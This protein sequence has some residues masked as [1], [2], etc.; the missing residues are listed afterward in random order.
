MSTQPL[1]GTSTCRHG[2][3]TA[4]WAAAGF[5]VCALHAGAAAGGYLYWER[6]PTGLLPPPAMIVAFEL[7]PAP[8]APPP[9]AAAPEPESEPEIDLP[10]LAE[11]EALPPSPP[12]VMAAVNAAVTLPEKQKPPK[13]KATEAKKPEKKK[14]VEKLPPETLPPTKVAQQA[15]AN[16]KM[17]LPRQPVAAAAPVAIGPTPDEL[18][19]ISAATNQWEL[20]FRR[21]IEKYRRYPKSAKRKHQEGTPVV[22]FVFDRA[23]NVLDAR[24]ARSSGFE[25]LDAEAIATFQRASPLPPLPPEIAGQRLRRSI[26]INFKL[27]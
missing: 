14:A 12:E 23:G 17:E 22:A 18:A 7:A 25:A 9:P 11:L 19:R 8:S 21:H 15:S 2:Q 5:F 27:E 1:F 13:K 10:P 6:P 26:A 4:R 20:A 24:I 16:T 3:G